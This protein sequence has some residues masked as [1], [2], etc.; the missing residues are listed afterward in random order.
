MIVRKGAL[1]VVADASGA[2]VYKVA[3][4]VNGVKLDDVECI[5]NERVPRTSDLG[6]DRPPRVVH[7]STRRGALETRDLHDEA[8]R[9]FAQRLSAHLDDISVAARQGVILFAPPRFLGMMRPHLSERTR[10]ALVAEI[11]KDLMK[12]DL[13][14][15][16]RM[17]GALEV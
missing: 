13:G 1:V 2:T 9:E 11:P 14:S 4:R 12:T 16:E 8:E 7:S 15:L 10:S 3:N 5:E 6:S 17:V